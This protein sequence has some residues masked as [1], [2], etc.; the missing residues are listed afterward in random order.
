MSI[1][2]LTWPT[3]KVAEALRP[4]A[5]PA[6]AMRGEAG[7]MRRGGLL[8]LLALA[9]ADRLKAPSLSIRDRV[10]CARPPAGRRGACNFGARL[11]RRFARGPR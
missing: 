7:E 11:M 5:R 3:H 2:A 9:A 10:P 1:D 8:E 6:F 4:I